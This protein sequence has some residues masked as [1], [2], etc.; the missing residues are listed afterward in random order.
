MTKMDT[1]FKF[2]WFHKF[3]ILID[4]KNLR[5]NLKYGLNSGPFYVIFIIEFEIELKTVKFRLGV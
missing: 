4:K 5:I 3:E 1:D 2:K